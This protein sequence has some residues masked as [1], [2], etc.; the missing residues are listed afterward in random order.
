V[1]FE[2]YNVNWINGRLPVLLRWL[3]ARKPEL[4]FLQELKSPAE[5]FLAAALEMGGLSRDLRTVI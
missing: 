4:V 5:K 1:K 3:A 2:T